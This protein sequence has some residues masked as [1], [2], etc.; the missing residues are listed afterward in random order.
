MHTQRRRERHLE[1]PDPACPRVQ[2][3]VPTQL[4][5]VPPAACRGPESCCRRPRQAWPGGANAR[6]GVVRPAP[7]HALWYARTNVASAQVGDGYLWVEIAAQLLNESLAD[8]AYACAT[9]SGS[10]TNN[11]GGCTITDSS[12]AL[13]HIPVPTMLQQAPAS[14]DQSTSR[15]MRLAS[16]VSTCRWRT[17]P[18]ARAGAAVP[19]QP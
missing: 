9:S 10:A 1:D 11:T 8:H 17:G 18:W 4:S 2:C 3:G 7:S 13:K 14:L 12:G 15:A 5:I 6:Q 19:T 16:P